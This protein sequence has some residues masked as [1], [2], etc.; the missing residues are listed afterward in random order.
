VTNVSEINPSNF[1][2]SHLVASKN[3]T[4]SDD[5][6]SEKFPKDVSVPISRGVDQPGLSVEGV[7]KSKVWQIIGSAGWVPWPWLANTCTHKIRSSVFKHSRVRKFIFKEYRQKQIQKAKVHYNLL[8]SL[9]DIYFLLILPGSPSRPVE[10]RRVGVSYMSFVPG[11]TQNSS[12]MPNGSRPSTGERRICPR[13][14]SQ[15]L[16]S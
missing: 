15:P 11:S 13:M 4:H 8:K 1:E 3:V 9:I 7:P 12:K 6:I 5:V 14:L 2:T 10:R 16:S